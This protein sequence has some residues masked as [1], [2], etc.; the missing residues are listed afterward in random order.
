CPG[1]RSAWSRSRPWPRPSSTRSPAPTRPESSAMAL[2]MNVRL[3]QGH[4]DAADGSRESVEW[5]PAPSRLFCA[6]V[7]SA[8][9]EAE[10]KAL[11]W[12]E[13]QSPPQIWAG[14]LPQR[15]RFR[16]ERYAVTNKTAP[17]G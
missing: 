13:N 3:L 7:A 9:T 12:L 11:E 2:V 16:S 1:K 5:P 4:Y 10:R 6:L 15:A 17:K 8:P 14:Q